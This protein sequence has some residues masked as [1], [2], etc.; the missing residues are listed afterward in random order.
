M[1][2]MQE[3]QPQ[4]AKNFMLEGWGALR[5]AWRMSDLAL[6]LRQARP[7][8]AAPLARLY[9]ET[10]QDTYAAILPHAMLAAMSV[11][12]HAA[13]IARAAGKN[14]ILVAE[15]RSL[16]LL[17]FAGF[18]AARDRGMGFDGEV[19]TLYVHPNFQGQGV[20]R[21]LL[22]GAF[23]E[24]AR[25]K[26]HTCVIWSHA[27]NHACF[28]YESLGGQRIAERQVTLG[29]QDVTEAAFGWKRLA[30]DRRKLAI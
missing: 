17:G 22:H 26:F 15:D 14:A 24:L 5:H 27:R 18:G 4:S 7:A 29:G 19:Y 11:D 12:L 2:D 20:G 9:V 28:F 10:W 3:R 25:K 30:L 6:S 13:R 21:M 1:L 16:G 8:D 23:T